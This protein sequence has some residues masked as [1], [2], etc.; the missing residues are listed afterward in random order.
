MG[1]NPTGN[2][3]VVLCF[4]HKDNIWNISDMK[5]EGR[6]Q[7]YKM[8]QRNKQERKR[9]PQAAWIFVLYSVF[10]VRYRSLRRADP[11][12]RGVLPTVV[13]LSVIK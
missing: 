1:S 10:V 2:M 6:I 7:R 4:L 13:C 8:D 12:S 3:D 11:L 9:I 5:K